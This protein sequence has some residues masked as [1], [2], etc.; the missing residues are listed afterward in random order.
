[1]DKQ[2][3]C[4]PPVDTLSLLSSLLVLETE[5]GNSLSIAFGIS[6][7]QGW[8]LPRIQQASALAWNPTPQLNDFI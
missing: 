1:M 5:P 4:S 6:F 7:F 3:V 8:N 2:F